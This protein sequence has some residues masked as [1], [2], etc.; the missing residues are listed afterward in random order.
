ME[1]TFLRLEEQRVLEKVLEGD[2]DSVDVFLVVMGEKYVK[3]SKTCLFSMSRSR[4]GCRTSAYRRG[5][6]G[7]APAG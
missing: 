3:L 7:S 6:S 1:L 5:L 4:D 2:L